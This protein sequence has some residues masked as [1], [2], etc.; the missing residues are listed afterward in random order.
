MNRLIGLLLWFIA[1]VF[2]AVALVCAFFLPAEFKTLSV[3]P[4]DFYAALFWMIFCGLLGFATA[5]SAHSVFTMRAINRRFYIFTN[6][7]FIILFLIVASVWAV[8]LSGPDYSRDRDLALFLTFIL[9]IVII[10]FNFFVIKHRLHKQ[11][12][13]K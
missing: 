9:A 6:V 10:A 4:E 8:S 1:F 3:E 13:E 7:I 2:I 5:N 11:V 12:P